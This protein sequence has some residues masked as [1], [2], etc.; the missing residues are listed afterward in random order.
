MDTLWPQ[1]LN[2]LRSGFLQ[3][4]FADLSLSFLV[5]SMAT[6]VSLL[7]GQLK[8]DPLHTDAE[9]SQAWERSLPFISHF[10]P[11][12]HTH[13]W[14]PPPACHTGH[15]SSVPSTPRDKWGRGAGLHAGFQVINK[16]KQNFLP[17][18][19]FPTGLQRANYAEPQP[20][21]SGKCFTLRMKSIF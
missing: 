8:W 11:S 9:R 16:S 21:L 20:Q 6:A 5:S 15:Q 4:S 13:L 14:L 2:Y 12:L 19:F 17:S 3:K 10:S 18:P 7:S 1:S